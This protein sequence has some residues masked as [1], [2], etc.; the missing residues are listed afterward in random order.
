MPV[1]FFA[2]AGGA[3]VPTIQWQF[4][5]DGINWYDISAS[6]CGGCTG[7][8]SDTYTSG[9]LSSFENDWQVRTVFTSAGGSVT[10]IAA[11]L[12]VSAY[13]FATPLDLAFDGAHLW[14]VNLHGNSVTELNAG[15]GSLVQTLS[16]GSYGFDSPGGIAFDG[17]HLWV[18]NQD[19]NSVTEL[20]ASDGS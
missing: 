13:G 12:T 8:N 10:T 1:T 7:I 4:S 9:R 2:A 3:P 19:G 15:D 20:N 5:T 6:S 11:T 14:I 16:G 17:T 18:A